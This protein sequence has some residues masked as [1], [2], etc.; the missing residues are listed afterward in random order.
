MQAIDPRELG[1]LRWRC[2][3]GQRE[4][5]DLLRRYVDLEYSAASPQDQEAFR[6]LLDSQDAEIH[7]YCLGRL[8][9]PTDALSALVS[10]ITA[11]RA[12]GDR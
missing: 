12:G 5:D 11:S 3:R 6:H 8:R 2:R 9:P 10:R 4:L 7:A 1:K